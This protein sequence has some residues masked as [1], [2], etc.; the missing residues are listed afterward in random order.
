MNLIEQFIE[1]MLAERGIAQ[2]S[3]SSYRRDLLDFANYLKGQDNLTNVSPDEIRAFVYS[4]SKNK[5]NP[6]SIS[7]KIS[8]IRSFYYF[9]ISEGAIQE[10]PAMHIDLP[11]FTKP[12]P[13]TLSVD[14]IKILLQICDSHSPEDIRLKCMIS[15]LY[16]SGI[17]VSELVSLKVT[18]IST[19]INNGKINNYITILGK[20]SKERLVII[21]D[22]AIKNLEEYLPIREIFIPLKDQENLYLFPSKSIAGHMTRQNFGL[23]LKQA[24]IKAGLDTAKISPH[25]LRHSFASHLLEGGADLRVIQELLG[26]TD[27]STTQIYT[28]VKPKQLKEIVKKHHPLAE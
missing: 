3:S 4:L 14:E 16:A 10:N 17:R 20:G 8:A 25:I 13:T 2:N 9:L 26:H 19:D 28:H 27:I 1:M 12:L 21:N 23:L 22:N 7:R 18:N 6:R 5:M 24:S 15:L 11:K